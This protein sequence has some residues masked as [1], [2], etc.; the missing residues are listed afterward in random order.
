[1]QRQHGLGEGDGKLSVHG[2]DLLCAG[3][4]GEDDQDSGARQYAAAGI[5][6][7]ALLRFFH[8]DRR[9]HVATE[10]VAGSSGV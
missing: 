2:S 1:V 9:R 7:A 8:N 4:S 5:R 10:D 3:W 6:I